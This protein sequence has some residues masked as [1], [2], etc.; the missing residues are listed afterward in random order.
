ME[1]TLMFVYVA[2]NGV[3]IGKEHILLQ[4]NGSNSLIYIS[5]I[6]S[7]AAKK[8][9]KDEKSLDTKEPKGEELPVSKASS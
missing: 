2:L 4:K 1:I 7:E 9:A 5:C 6:Q 8:S 3:N